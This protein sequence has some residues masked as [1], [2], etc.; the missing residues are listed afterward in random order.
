MLTPA[1]TESRDSA[2]RAYRNEMR[3]ARKIGVSEP[4]IARVVC[5]FRGEHP[6]PDEFRAALEQYVPA[7]ALSDPGDEDYRP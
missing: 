1:V 6:D 4:N 7:G 2:R 5:A 3:W